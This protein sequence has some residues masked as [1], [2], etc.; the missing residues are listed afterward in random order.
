MTIIQ[1]SVKKGVT[2]TAQV[3]R[4]PYSLGRTFK[5]KK[6]ATTWETKV[7]AAIDAANAANIPFIKEDYLRPRG[8]RKKPWDPEPVYPPATPEPTPEEEQAA[9]DRD[10]APRA[11]WT[12]DKALDHFDRTVTEHVKSRR[13]DRARIKIWREHEIAMLRLNQVTPTHIAEFCRTRVN[14]KGKAA[15]KPVAATTLA[16]ECGRLSSLYQLAATPK[17]SLYHDVNW[18]WGLTELRNPAHKPPIGRKPPARDRRL[19]ATW[20]DGKE[21]SEETA[22]WTALEAGLDADQMV[23][24][25]RLA[26]NTGMRRG[27]LLDMRLGDYQKSD[28]GWELH[29]RY[30]DTKNLQIRRVQLGQE[31][32]ATIRKLIGRLPDNSPLDTKLFALSEDAAAYRFDRALEAAKIQGYTFHDLRHDA[33]SRMAEAGWTLPEIMAQSGHKTKEALLRYLNANRVSVRRKLDLM[34]GAQP[35]PVDQAA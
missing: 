11:D 1:R 7:E 2:Y 29:R 33:C 25:V 27:E 10:P 23:P 14:R 18:G 26:I 12:L 19:G 34:D 4:G 3:R 15:G 5:A 20:V 22:L 30:E 6:E 32:N 16:A 8:P 24:L 9:I 35:P 17:T 13:Q 21:V 28:L 31:A